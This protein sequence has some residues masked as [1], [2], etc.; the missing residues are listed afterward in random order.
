MKLPFTSGP[1]DITN[2]DY[3]NADPYKEFCSSSML[4][5]L[6]VS[7]KYARYSLDNPEKKE[8]EAMSQGSVYHSMLASLTNKGDLSGF[9]GEYFIFDPP[10]NP[11]TN[12]SYGF[13]TKAYQEAVESEIQS[14]SGKLPCS[15]DQKKVAESMIDELLNGN[16]HLSPTV[17]HLIKIGTAEQSHFIEHLGQKFKYR[18]DLKTDRKIVDWKK[19]KLG[20]PKP[21]AFEREIIKYNYH[22]SAAFYQFFEFMLTGK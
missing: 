5:L 8:S 4:K 17:N 3:H 14:N 7:P 12:T 22:I 13:E 9:D 6:M 20:S 11:S 10:K 19:T 18:T 21:E 16:P 2:D 15:A 1:N